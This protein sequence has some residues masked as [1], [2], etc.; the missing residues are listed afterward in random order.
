LSFVCAPRF[1]DKP[2]YSFEI[3]K[4]KS[5]LF[6]IQTDSVTEAKK[7]LGEIAHGIKEFE[8]SLKDIEL[9]DD[10]IQM[11]KKARRQ[12]ISEKDPVGHAQRHGI[13]IRGGKSPFS[14]HIAALGLL[15][16]TKDTS[17]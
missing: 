9:F 4:D 10:A 13:T 16:E 7:L 12:A 1:P 2:L 17:R 14:E 15:G 8:K 11:A 6:Q 5:I 3:R